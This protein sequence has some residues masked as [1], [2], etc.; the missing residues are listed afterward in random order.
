MVSEMVVV[1]ESEVLSA[2]ALPAINKV[3]VLAIWRLLISTNPKQAIMLNW[4]Q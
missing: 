3:V 1:M 2:I 4:R